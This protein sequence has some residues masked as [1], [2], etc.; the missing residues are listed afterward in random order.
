MLTLFIEGCCWL[1]FL[2]TLVRLLECDEHCLRYCIILTADIISCRVKLLCNDEVIGELPVIC[3]IS[4][5][6]SKQCI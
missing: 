4:G 1:S 3:Y 6:F 5:A 2:L